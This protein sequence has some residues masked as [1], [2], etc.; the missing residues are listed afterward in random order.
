MANEQNLI[1]FTSDQSREEA[2][3]NGQKGGIASGEARRK[4]R[5]LREIGDM[6]GKLPIKSEQN[7]QLLKQAGLTDEDMIRDV[8]IMFRLATKAENGDP[9]AT[10]LFAKLRS[11]LK[12]QVETTNIDLPAPRLAKDRSERNGPKEN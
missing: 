8:A 9:R 5:T 11:Q 12:E 1:P 6:I 7:K 4:Q 2:K 10:E 3:K